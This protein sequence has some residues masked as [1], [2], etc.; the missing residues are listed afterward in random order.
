MATLRPD[1]L[2]AALSRIFEGKMMGRASWFALTGGEQLFAEGDESDTLYL[3]RSGRLGVFRMEQGQPGQ[4][5]GVVRSGEPV[6]EMA[7]LAGTPHTASVVALRDTEILSLPREAFFEAARSEPDLMVELSRLMIHRARERAGGA[8]EPS[9]FGF[10]SARPQPIR[11]FVERIAA[12]I[13]ALGFTCKVIDQSALSS[14]SEWF[15]RVEDDH[16]YVLYVAE[17][18]QPA[19]ANLC[20]RQVDRLFIV[21][22]ALM[23]PPANL[24][25]RVGFGDNRRLTDLI[26]LRDPRMTKPANTRV[27]LNALEPDRWFHCVEGLASDAERMARVVTGTAVGLVLSGGGARAYCHIGAVKALEEAKVP[28]D[29]LGGSSMGA[30]VAAGPA[31]GWS[32][33]RLDYEIRRAFV[34]SDPLADITLPLIAMSRARKVAGLLERAYG[35]V[36]IADL[37]LPFFAVSS[38][39]TSG[40]IVV[41]R[42]GLM[43]KA[44]RASIAIPGVLPPVVIDE[45]VLVDG[46]VLKNFPT[47]VMRQ[48]NSGPI[49]GV[50]M[51]QTRGVDPQSLENPPSWWKWIASGA[52]KRGP[53]I[54]SILMRSATITTDTEME[55]SRA[56]ADV[57]ILP[58]TGTTD[59]RD[60]KAYDAPVASGY[61]A[62]KAALADLPCRVTELRHCADNKTVRSEAPEP[63]EA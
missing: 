20:T 56:D 51:S 7:M 12:A 57:L 27:W 48:L 11:A 1:T 45:Q 33:E 23:A 39:L 40:R 41:H 9:V 18:D 31:L 4:F 6:G 26:L 13:Q 19:W 42:S 29:F 5:L 3:V 25:R 21:G 17:Q 34:E 32:F 38:N 49:I 61:E 63:T 28:L 60:W 54:V 52:W 59:I 62:T 22:S 35:D 10:V 43:R 53:P 2:E 14:A 46:A 16:D 15:S 36:D 47:S 37:P 58:K 30:V 8:T 50:D 44:M 24:P 55:Q